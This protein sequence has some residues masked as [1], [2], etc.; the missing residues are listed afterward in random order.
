MDKEL[1]EAY[2]YVFNKVENASY[3]V[4][5]QCI[6]YIDDEG[7]TNEEFCDSCPV[8]KTL[9]RLRYMAKE[10]TWDA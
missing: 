6:E 10:E 1:A 8:R 9:D 3:T 4:C 7:E 5:G 2:L